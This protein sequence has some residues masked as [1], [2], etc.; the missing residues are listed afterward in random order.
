[1]SANAVKKDDLQNKINQKLK[2]KGL[3]ADT[4]K[5]V[6]ISGSGKIYTGLTSEEV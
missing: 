5:G 6:K 2:E 3:I 4:D 1:M